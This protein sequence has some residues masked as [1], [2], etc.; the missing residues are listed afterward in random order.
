MPLLPVTRRIA[1]ITRDS[2]GAPLG[3]VSVLLYSAVIFTLIS[4]LISD[5]NGN[6]VFSRPSND[7]TPYFVAAFKAGTPN[8]SGVTYVDVVGS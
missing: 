3:G 6:F 4:S 5:D 2:T 8:V 1:G 7:N